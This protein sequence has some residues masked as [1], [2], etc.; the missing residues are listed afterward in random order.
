MNP[1]WPGMVRLSPSV[2]LRCALVRR[3]V[4]GPAAPRSL[5]GRG[6]AW[7]IR[8]RLSRIACRLGL[9]LYL[10]LTDASK[11][12]LLARHPLR[13]VIASAF[14]AVLRILRLVSRFGLVQSCLHVGGQLRFLRH[15]PLVAHRLL[16][17]GVGPQLGAAH[18][19]MT[20]LYKSGR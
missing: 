4:E 12:A 8:I 19:H 3:P 5:H 2:K 16:A 15:H 9:Q 6:E 17:T 20:K 13:H 11:P 18:R 10:G 7:A 1:P 14:A